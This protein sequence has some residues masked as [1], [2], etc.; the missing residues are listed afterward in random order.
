MKIKIWSVLFIL[1]LF[2]ACAPTKKIKNWISSPSVQKGGNESFGVRFEPLKGDKKFFVS[3][4]LSVMNKTD[5]SLKIDWNK[6]RYIYKGKPYGGFVFYGIN[7]ADIK[8]SIPPDLIAPGKLFSKEIFPTNL[9]AFTPI[10]EEVL[11]TKGKGIYPGP[12]P[13]GKNGISL[14]IMKGDQEVVEKIV[15]NIRAVAK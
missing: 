9:V 11:N 10:R 5:K 4:R 3:F 12:I 6:T 1:I 15:L 13:A 8:N 14:V 7:P 2:T